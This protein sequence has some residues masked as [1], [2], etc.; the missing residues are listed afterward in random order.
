MSIEIESLFA[1]FRSLT[2]LKMLSKIMIITTRSLSHRLAVMKSHISI[3]CRK[4]T[5]RYVHKEKFIIT[6]MVAMI[7]A[8]YD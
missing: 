3:W 5:E 6:S 2:S 7:V 8:L 4:N 1:F